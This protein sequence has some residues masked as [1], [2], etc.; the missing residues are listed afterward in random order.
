MSDESNPWKK[1]ET[2]VV[3]ENDWLR[4]NED[5]VI[6][7]AGKAGIYGVVHFKNKAIAIIPLDE[8]YNTWIV[9]Q[10]R[11]APAT[12]EWEVPEGGCPEDELP[13]DTARRELQEEAGLKAE[14]LELIME[15]QLSNSATDEI[16]YT[17]VAR[18]LTIMDT[19]HEETEIIRVRKL[20]FEQL[21]NMAMNGEI[22]DALSVASILKAKILIDQGKL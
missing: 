9:G 16:S 6:T 1:L 18:G 13:I 3:Y 17:Y 8:E 10:F 20:P 2:A 7:P 4:I 22:K 21:F 5:Q 14:K 11:Y 15:M 12:Y 19:E